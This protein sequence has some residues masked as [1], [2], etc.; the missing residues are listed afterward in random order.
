MRSNCPR[1]GFV[2]LQRTQ[3]PFREAN[4]PLKRWPG[5]LWPQTLANCSHQCLLTHSHGLPALSLCGPTQCPPK[6]SG[7]TPIQ[8]SWRFTHG[9]R[10][11]TSPTNT[12]LR[13]AQRPPSCCPGSGVHRIQL[14]PKGKQHFVSGVLTSRQTA[15]HRQGPGQP[16]EHTPQ[17][18]TSVLGDTW[19]L[20]HQAVDLDFLSWSSVFHPE[21]PTSCERCTAE[22][23]GSLY[24]HGA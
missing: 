3:F 2:Y 16:G 1:D 18:N 6:H 20:C 19:D 13:G 7:R 9:G 5:C 10:C 15:S 14:P 23:S 11:R 21:P 17:E 22:Y 8:M 4:L 12:A 24:A